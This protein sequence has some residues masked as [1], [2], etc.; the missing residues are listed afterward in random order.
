MVISYL[1]GESHLV[2]L[3]EALRAAAQL[4]AVART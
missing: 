4:T 3:Q 1:T 2:G